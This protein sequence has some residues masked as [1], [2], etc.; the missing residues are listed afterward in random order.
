MPSTTSALLA[1]LLYAAGS[2]PLRPLAGRPR[3]PRAGG[4]AQ[5]SASPAAPLSSFPALPPVY[6][7]FPQ[8]LS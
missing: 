3:V 4:G 8:I 1:S 7:A 5:L 2:G 6:A